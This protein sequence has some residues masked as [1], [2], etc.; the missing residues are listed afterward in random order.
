MPKKLT[1]EE[2]LEVM[3]NKKPTIIP[4]EE[5]RGS[6]SSIDFKCDICGR[7][8]H[9]V[10]IRILG[11][12]NQGCPQCYHG[13]QMTTKDDF[14]ARSKSNPHVV[15]VEDYNG[16]KNKINVKCVYCG[17]VFAM[18]ADSI[19]DGRGHGSCIQKNVERKPSRTQEEFLEQCAKVNK[20]VAPL[21]NYTRTSD[22]MFFRCNICGHVWEA[23]IGH[24]LQGESGCPM[25]KISKGERRIFNYLKNKNISFIPQHKFPDCKDIL[26]LPFDF[27]LPIQNVC[28]EYDGEQHFIEVPYFK[29]SL[30]YIQ[31]HDKIKNL[32]C[33]ENDINLIRI[34]YTD[35]N[36]IEVILNEFIT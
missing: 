31:K 11:T 22:K 29:Y 33:E 23:K 5:Y 27:Y 21:G 25:C 2:F 16:V 36:N 35:F 8:F 6:T 17:K 4:L 20:D 24:I 10:P 13:R 15:V 1:N 3:K 7:I 28:I 14:L 9:N 32:Y 26:A 34:P 18:R 19:L 30:E 12:R